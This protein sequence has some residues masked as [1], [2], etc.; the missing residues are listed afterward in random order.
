MNKCHPNAFCTDTQGSYNC[1]CHPKYIGDGLNCEGMFRIY[2]AIYIKLNSHKR[3]HLLSSSSRLAQTKLSLLRLR[4][5]VSIALVT[6]HYVGIFG[7][8]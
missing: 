7:I 4:I 6:I 5:R 8:L 2:H 1:S 3:E